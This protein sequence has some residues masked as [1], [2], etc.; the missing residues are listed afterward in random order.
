MILVSVIIPVY[1]TGR[2]LEQCL[3]SVFSQTLKD[4]E[5]ICIDD[6]SS[7]N[8]LDI[9][10]EFTGQYKN[11]TVIK[12]EN[13]GVGKTRNKGIDYAR[14]K[15]IAFVDSDD[16][17]FCDSA[18]EDLY[19]NAEK[20]NVPVCGGSI[21]MNKNDTITK[22]ANDLGTY[23][24]V[25]Q[26][27][28]R[29]FRDVNRT[30]GYLCYIYLKDFLI[31]ENIRFPEYIRYQD[32]VFFIKALAKAQYFY[33]MTKTVYCYRKGHK[34]MYF[35]LQKVMDCVCAVKDLL[36]ISKEYEWSAMHEFV[37][38]QQLHGDLSTAIY[39]YIK[40]GIS[41]VEK[42]IESINSSIDI[43]LIRKAGGVTEGL[44]LLPLDKIDDYFDEIDRQEFNFISSIRPYS[45]IIIFGAGYVGRKLL[46][47]IDS[48]EE[49][50]DKEVIFAVSEKTGNPD[51]I[52]GR[53]VC[54]IK[55]IQPDDSMIVLIAALKLRHSD[56]I[57]VLKD[58]HFN[59]YMVA[60]YQEFSLYGIKGRD[61]Q[62]MEMM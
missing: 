15:Y 7:D 26:D 13:M 41:D 4:I 25:S 44:F 34:R 54:Y 62:D 20:Y 10:Y 28:I 33:A 36:D 11:L 52:N 23:L 12:Q 6:G 55:D 2:Y 53:M 49:F 9:L 1:N 42:C 57:N 51:S 60:D 24:N 59:D 56:M 50:L 32:T 19:N 43:E 29:N 48:R 14:G 31:H 27:G 5:V 45:K 18:L 30:G 58:Y 17:Y 47:Y 37:I 46:D 21:C 39:R 22:N 35:T 61:I 3:M 16:Y 40:A 8:S 38:R